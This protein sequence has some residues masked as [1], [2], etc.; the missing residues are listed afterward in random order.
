VLENSAAQPSSVSYTTPTLSP[1]AGQSVIILTY[2][3]SANVRTFSAET[4]GGTGT[5]VTERA[6]AASVTVADLIVASTSGTYAGAAT[7]SNPAIV[8]ASGIVI[9]QEAAV[10]SATLPPFPRRILRL[11]A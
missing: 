11:S 2:Y 1:T 8:G 9:Y 10:A 7:T 5:G 6:D 3:C 4:I